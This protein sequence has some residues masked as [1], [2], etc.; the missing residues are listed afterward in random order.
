MF[1]GLFTNNHYITGNDT[2]DWRDLHNNVVSQYAVHWKAIGAELGLE[3]YHIAN[4][5]EDHR[6]RTEDGCAAML[7]KW[8]HLGTSPTWG[9][10]DDTI[11]KIVRQKGLSLVPYEDS[12]DNSKPVGKN[13]QINIFV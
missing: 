5:S 9:V 12:V 1:Y 13:A 2:P 6:N 3:H 4:I 11:N 7:M 10:L 8:L